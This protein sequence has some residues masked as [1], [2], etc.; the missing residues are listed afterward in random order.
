MDLNGAV[1]QPR[2]TYVAGKKFLVRT[3]GLEADEALA[4]RRRDLEY[5]REQ[6][7]SDV[8]PSWAR[9]GASGAS[10]LVEPWVNVRLIS[11]LD[12]KFWRSQPKDAAASYVLRLFELWCRIERAG[13]ED[14]A[15]QV[16]FLPGHALRGLVD[17]NGGLMLGGLDGQRVPVGAVRAEAGGRLAALFHQLGGPWV[18]RADAVDRAS[19]ARVDRVAAALRRGFGARAE[20]GHTGHRPARAARDTDTDAGT[21]VTE[22]SAAQDPLPSAAGV[23]PPS[24]AVTAVSTLDGRQGGASLSS[25]GPYSLLSSIGRGGMG[26]I[27]LAARNGRSDALCA[28]KALRAENATDEEALSMFIDEANLMGRIEDPHVL[29]LLDVG[30]DGENYFFVTEYL[31]GRPLVRLMIDAYAKDG[32]MDPCVCAMIAMGAARGLAAAHEAEGADGQPLGIVHRDVSPQNIF[33][34]Y[35]GGV[36]LLDFG[37][38]RASRRLAKTAVGLVKG[39]AAYMSPEQA[40]GRTVDAR[41]DIFSLGVCLWEMLAGQRLFKRPAEYDTLLAVVRAPI[42]PPSTVRG[43][44]ALAVPPDLDAIVLDMLAR[45]PEAR[46]ASARALVQRLEKFIA[47][48]CAAGDLLQVLM[49]RLFGAEAEKEDRIISGLLTGLDGD[50]AP[51]QLAAVSGLASTTDLREMTVV[52]VPGSLDALDAFGSV[53]AG[54]EAEVWVDETKD[55]TRL[56]GAVRGGSR[57]RRWALGGALLAMVALFGTEVYRRGWGRAWLGQRP[58]RLG[59]APAP[60]RPDSGN[61]VRPTEVGGPMARPVPAPD[62]GAASSDTDRPGAEDAGS[63]PVRATDWRSVLT[64]Y[65]FKIRPWRGGLVLLRGGRAVLRSSRPIRAA[66]VSGGGVLLQARGMWPAAVV[67]VGP[68]G[69]DGAPDSI[70]PLSI[71]RCSASAALEGETLALRYAGRTVELSLGEG[72]LFDV[73]VAAP[74]RAAAGILQPLGLRFEGGARSRRGTCRAEW[75][76]DHLVLRR[77]PVGRFRVRWRDAD[78]AD[79]EPDSELSLG[80]AGVRGAVLLNATRW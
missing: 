12:T 35:G 41:S 66:V 59:R 9:R 20:V 28:L 14:G 53:G 60:S 56:L 61:A 63:A 17:P 47:S 25:I 75:R 69:L 48:H 78:G 15:A 74:E 58:E 8:L 31:R 33:V 36:K 68:F 22:L 55:A 11:L 43:A 42:P 80:P 77:L 72:R 76:S 65:G 51:A 4:C 40:S 57:I 70:V 19:T 32:G 50:R 39:K 2:I 64:G 18:E 38:A 6:L 73:A 24:V 49:H 13:T 54:L 27:F 71:G 7:P 3:L 62:A 79:L 29:R 30:R 16:G 10:E 45:E 5:L 67:W 34:T 46:P 26:E 21:E 37:V 1:G 23:E 52:A 44:V